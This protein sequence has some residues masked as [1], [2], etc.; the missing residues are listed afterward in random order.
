MKIFCVCQYCGHV[1][2]DDPVLE[3]NFRDQKIYYYCN[4]CV[5]EGKEGL[6]VFKFSDNMK[7]YP[8]IGRM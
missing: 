6:N 1:E 5:K 3:I 2:K 4:K 8:R 7:P